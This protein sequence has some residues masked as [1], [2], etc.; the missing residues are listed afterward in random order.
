MKQ[1]GMLIVAFGLFISLLAGC[2][3]KPQPIT[4]GL[5]KDGEFDPEEWGKVYPLE[6]ESWL[7]T[8]EPKP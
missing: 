2:A 4:A 1:Y 8:K 7:K 6:Y 5:I 3:P